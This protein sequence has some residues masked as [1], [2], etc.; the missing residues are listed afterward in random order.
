MAAHPNRRITITWA[1]SYYR[2]GVDDGIRVR[3]DASGAVDMP[4]RIFAYRMLPLN[5]RTGQE[6]GH[7]DHVCSPPD[8][9]DYPED[10]PRPGIRP[11][12]F[13]LSYVDL[14][15]RSQEEVAD[16]VEAVLEDVRRL[17][18]TLDRMDTLQPGDAEQVGIS[19][20]VTSSSSSSSESSQSDS[21][22][23]LGPLQTITAVATCVLTAG[24]GV[25]WVKH[26]DGVGPGVQDVGGDPDNFYRVR[27]HAK[28]VSKLLILQGFDLEDLPADATI[29]GIAANLVLRDNTADLDDNSLD[30]ESSEETGPLLT[31][32]KLYHPDLGPQGD[33]QAERQVITGTDFQTIAV[34]GDDELWGRPLT[35]AELK[36]ADAGVCLVVYQS[37]FDDTAT[38]DVDGV[39]L[40]LT[41]R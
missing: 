9:A 25:D 1:T 4:V 15:V 30:S 8:L 23:S 35:A 18:H 6:A 33:N 13:R 28:A 27:L 31:M 26:G 32:L 22:E 16:L 14:M 12:W 34:G 20:D 11:E 17:K 7:F 40:T 2:I 5:P 39:E 29:V 36:R 3:F 10:E 19:P 37:S 24:F 41:Y 21:S 38:V